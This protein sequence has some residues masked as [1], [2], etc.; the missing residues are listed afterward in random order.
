MES[1]LR[2]AIGADHVRRYNLRLRRTGHS[3]SEHLPSFVV[4][5]RTLVS[6]HLLGKGKFAFLSVLLVAYVVLEPVPAECFQQ[7][8]L[9]IVV[10]SAIVDE[11]VVDVVLHR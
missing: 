8:R 10:G 3:E 4:T 11:T 7:E 6:E 1:E 2:L 5:L 9:L